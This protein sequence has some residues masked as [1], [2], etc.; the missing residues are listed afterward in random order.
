MSDATATYHDYADRSRSKSSLLRRIIRFV[1]IFHAAPRPPSMADF[2]DRDLAD[3][4]L[5]RHHIVRV[6]PREMRLF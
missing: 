6:D 3:L 2:T 1:S 5:R 4:N